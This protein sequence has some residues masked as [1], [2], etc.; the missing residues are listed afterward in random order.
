LQ[1]NIR[2]YKN[3]DVKRQKMWKIR[4]KNVFLIIQMK[5]R[6]IKNMKGIKLFLSVFVIS[7]SQILLPLETFPQIKELAGIEPYIDSVLTKFEVPGAG[8]AVVKDGKVLLTKG[9]G[10]KN[11]NE[12]ARVDEHTLFGIASNSKAFTATALALLVEEGKIKWDSPVREYLPWFQMPDHFITG[13]ITVRDLLVHRSGL[14][15][16]AGDLLWYPSSL[17][18]RKEIC[19][20]L[21][22]LPLKTSFRSAYA[23]DNVLYLVAGEVIEA[24]SGLTWEDFV[25]KRILHKLSMTDTKTRPSEA[26]KSDNCAAPHVFVEGKLQTVD[27]FVNDNS[28]P[29]GGITASAADMAKWMIMHLD[30]GKINDSENLFKPTTTEQLWQY[31]TPLRIPKYSGALAPLKPNFS[32]YALG[33]QVKDYRG[34]K[35]VTH[36]GAYTGYLS[37][38]FM[39]PD[40]KLGIVVLTNQES[41]YAFNSITYKIVDRFLTGED[42]DWLKAFADNKAKSDD[43]NDNEEKE[44]NEGRK[45]DT[46]PSLPMESYAGV[47]KDKWYGDI[48]ISGSGNKY[49]IEFSKTPSLKGE[50]SHWQ[51]DTF[52]IKWHDRSLNAD[53]F[54]TFCLN[55][56]GEVEQ[57]KMVPMLSKTDFSFDFQDLLLKPVK[58]NK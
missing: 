39:V 22:K 50:L 48:T 28:N 29:A 32:G 35:I 2:Q 54:I 58:K 57:A 4:T 33:F 51:Y 14:G 26:A 8:V 24:V 46:R 11:M 7:A 6:F 19:Q 12:K 31:V 15:L 25:A 55:A 53:A 44:L 27:M 1:K 23:Y 20:R 34:R 47:Y 3:S 21:N 30:S 43:D 42:C 9:F 18:T 52:E 10:V 5:K 41:A 45:K 37:Q 56:K 49:E 36:T 17:F 16:G 38:L 13:E 40:I